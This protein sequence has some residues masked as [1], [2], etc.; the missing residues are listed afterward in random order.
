MRADLIPGLTFPEHFTIELPLSKSVVARQLLLEYVYNRPLQQYASAVEGDFSCE[1][2]RVLYRALSLLEKCRGHSS[3]EVLHLE[4]GESGTAYRFLLVLALFE[5]RPLTLH[6]APR[7]RERLKAS[8]FAPFLRLGAVIQHKP[9]LCQT[10]IT[11]APLRSGSLSSHD[12]SSSQYLSALL[13]TEPLHPAPIHLDIDTAT[14]SYSYIRLTQAM[15]Q[16]SLARS[17]SF[18]LERDWSAASFWYLLMALHPEIRTI[19]FPGLLID[20]AQPDVALDTFF[21]PFGVGMQTGA[22]L[23]SRQTPC[24]TSSPLSFDLRQNLDLFTPL[25][26]VAVAHQQ[27]FLIE[28][29]APLRLKESDRIESTLT[30]LG[31]IGAEGFIVSEDSAAWSGGFSALHRQLVPRGTHALQPSFEAYQ[32]HRIA[33]AMAA[34][35]TAL[36]AGAMVTGLQS[37]SKSYPAFISQLL[38]LGSL[39]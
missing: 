8:D 13:L 20:S 33:M 2:I 19:A 25:V 37:A 7:M 39:R 28:G 5:A 16:S 17:G 26:T 3:S 23:L 24:L 36:P 31:Q 22:P 34:L 11:P 6:Y 10:S 14:P 21:T 30:N 1:D 15:L 29:T 4:S 32:D 35:A 18:P 38:N 9:E 27:P 12:W